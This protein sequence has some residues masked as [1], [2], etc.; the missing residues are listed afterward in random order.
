MGFRLL[1]Y[2]FCDNTAICDNFSIGGFTSGEKKIVF[3]LLFMYVPNPWDSLTRSL[4]N[5]FIHIFDSGHFYS[6]DI[7]VMVL[8]TALSLKWIHASCSVRICVAREYLE[9]VLSVLG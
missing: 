2:D 6:C 8:I 1:W 4:A 7:P 9:A 5:A 3:F